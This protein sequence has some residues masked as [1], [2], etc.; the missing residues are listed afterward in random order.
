MIKKAD[1]LIA[2]ASA[3]TAEKSM[4]ALKKSTHILK[5]S[6][7]G[8][9]SRSISSGASIADDSTISTTSSSTVSGMEDFRFTYEE[10]ADPEIFFVPYVWEVIVSCV[11][12]SSLEWNKKRIKV[13]ALIEHMNESSI[14]DSQENVSNLTYAKDL[15]DVV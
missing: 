3:R 2:E 14:P 1:G 15:A 12:A 10:E 4:E 8:K 9:S 11:T 13:F 6:K 5:G 7:S